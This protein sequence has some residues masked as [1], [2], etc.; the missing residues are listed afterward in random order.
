MEGVKGE[1]G[2]WRKSHKGSLGGSSVVLP[3]YITLHN[4][5]SIPGNKKEK[6]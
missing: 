2:R 5:G 6:S 1:R 4:P 3:L